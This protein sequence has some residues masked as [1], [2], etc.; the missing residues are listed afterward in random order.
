MSDKHKSEQTSA[1][2][3]YSH[4]L[5]QPFEHSHSASIL[6]SVRGL[7]FYQRR[8]ELPSRQPYMGD[9]CNNHFWI[10]FGLHL[11]HICMVRPRHWF[12]YILYGRRFEQAPLSD[13]R[14]VVLRKPSDPR[15]LHCYRAWI[16]QWSGVCLCQN[17]REEDQ[18][19]RRLANDQD[20][21]NE[22]IT[23]LVKSS[24]EQKSMI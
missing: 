9:Q 6:H 24:V 22:G 18:G 14:S 12:D 5:Q 7:V 19:S 10:V 20:A 23:R 11:V 1:D 21:H 2:S 4:V 17:Q 3:V 16:R 8:I 13:Q 15:R